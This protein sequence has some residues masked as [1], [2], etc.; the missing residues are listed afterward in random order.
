MSLI[1]WDDM[2]KIG[3][4]F[5]KKMRLVGNFALSALL[6]IG[7]SGCV[8]NVDALAPTYY[9]ES[10]V[11]AE[12]EILIH[13][14]KELEAMNKN[15]ESVERQISARIILLKEELRAFL[16][17][18]L[19]VPVTLDGELLTYETISREKKYI[20]EEIGITDPN[21]PREIGVQ[22]EDGYSF[23]Y[24]TKRTLYQLDVDEECMMTLI[25]FINSKKTPTSEEILKVLKSYDAAKDIS[26][27]YRTAYLTCIDEKAEVGKNT[28]TTVYTGTIFNNTEYSLR[29]IDLTDKILLKVRSDYIA[30]TGSTA[31]PEDYL[32][33]AIE[34]KWL[35]VHRETG[36]TDLLDERESELCVAVT[37]VQLCLDHKGMLANSKEVDIRI[38]TLQNVLES[39]LKGDIE[40]QK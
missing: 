27:G 22:E 30:R 26:Y 16:E 18:S 31:E 25:R 17:Q 5:P 28:E 4:K 13:D 19:D 23:Y 32:L 6:T 40:K 8:K 3:K 15:T 2:N 35:I 39:Y 21:W 29:T 24:Y 20:D 1:G 36:A 37:N 38:E 33:T 9:V 11:P 7:L 34:G 10:T 12:L 14:C